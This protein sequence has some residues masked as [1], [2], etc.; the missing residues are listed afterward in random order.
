MLVEAADVAREAFQRSVIVQA[1]RGQIAERHLVPPGDQA[2]VRGHQRAHGGHGLLAAPGRDHVGTGKELAQCALVARWQAQHGH[3]GSELAARVGSSQRGGEQ[4]GHAAIA[5]AGLDHVDVA[6]HQPFDQAH[7]GGREHVGRR[8][9]YHAAAGRPGLVLA[10][11]V[12][13][14][15]RARVGA[16]E[17]AAQLFLHGVARQHGGHGL[18]HG[19]GVLSRAGAAGFFEQCAIAAAA[20]L[21]LLRQLVAS[22]QQRLQREGPG[23]RCIDVRAQP[24]QG[25]GQGIGINPLAKPV[26]RAGFRGQIG[27]W[28][29]I[30]FR[31]RAADPPLL[32]RSSCCWRYRRGP[33]PRTTAWGSRSH[34]CP[35]GGA[36]PDHP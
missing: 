13:P 31:P 26:V 35:Q 2:R 36:R 17:F 9:V 28:H 32:R 12:A 8:H 22:C 11:R 15:Q 23:Q 24:L 4:R 19:G 33:A 29:G 21:Q 6:R 1:V 18:Q 3:V 30:P 7:G 14:L 5:C 16:A 25:L 27:C 20:R 10:P 34:S